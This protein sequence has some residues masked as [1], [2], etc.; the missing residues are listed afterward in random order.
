MEGS[1]ATFKVRFLSS[2][3]NLYYKCS[4]NTEVYEE[5]MIGFLF[6]F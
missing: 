6:Y 2:K 4:D 3:V 1:A 5:A